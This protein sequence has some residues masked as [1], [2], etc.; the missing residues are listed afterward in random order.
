MK[1]KLK[2]LLPVILLMVVCLFTL[3]GCEDTA[4]TIVGYTIGGVL[5]V[6]SFVFRLLLTIVGSIIAL[7]AGVA[8]RKEHCA[9][10]W[11]RIMVGM[12]IW[13]F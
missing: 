5:G 9:G 6:L 1:M 8:C 13:G 12:R 2:K 3:T 10:W 11:Q 4:L 7:I